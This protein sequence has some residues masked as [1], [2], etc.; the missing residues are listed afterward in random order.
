MSNYVSDNFEDPNSEN[1]LNFLFDTTAFNR[2]AEHIEWIFILEQSLAKGA[3]YYKTANQDYELMGIGA[4]TYDK[5]GI[6]HPIASEIFE[7]KIPLF[8]DIKERLQ[9]KRVSSMASFMRGHWILDGTYR[10][11]DDKSAIGKMTDE[12][13][14]AN[15]KLREKHPFAQ[16]Y[17][18]MTAEAAIFNHCTLVTDDKKLKNIVNKHFP[19]RAIQTKELVELIQSLL[20]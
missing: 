1:K 5:D 9:I 6:P 4:K 19:Q 14:D 2:L 3:R 12:I 18:A 11:Y 16:H 13:F 7:T 15:K 17:D 10:L 8:D 20:N